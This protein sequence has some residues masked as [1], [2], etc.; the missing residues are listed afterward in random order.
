[1]LGIITWAWQIH[2]K[3]TVHEMGKYKPIEKYVKSVYEIS[4]DISIWKSILDK[5]VEGYRNEDFIARELFSSIFTIYD[6]D[7]ISGNGWLKVYQ[8]RSIQITTKNIDEQKAS[9]FRWIINSSILRIYNS[10][11][12][13]LQ[14]VIIDEYLN[15]QTTNFGKR[16]ISLVRSEINQ[17]FKINNFGKPDT[18]NNRHLIRYLKFKSSAVTEFI[19]K[20]VRIDLKSNWEALFELISILRNVIAHNGM[21]I[22]KDTLNQIK[23]S[24]KDIF[25]RY[26]KDET[27]IEDLVL[28][29]PRQEQVLNFIKLINE[30]GINL[31]K[32][33][34]NEDNLE[35]CS[36]R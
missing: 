22:E 29:D 24:A 6:V 15:Q 9:F 28:L 14:E 35:F 23:Q 18:K 10:L 3:S 1:M 21:M 32:F 20:P 27:K 34:K 5:V 12:I 4:T 13:L 8:D 26:F 17:C 11:E 31:V 7:R 16:Q 36:F 2:S 30:C 19:Q 25:E 33:V